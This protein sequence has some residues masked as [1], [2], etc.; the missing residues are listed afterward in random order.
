ME[1]ING[2]G[3]EAMK[4]IK[5]EPIKCPCCGLDMTAEIYGDDNVHIAV[6]CEH[7][8]YPSKETMNKKK[9]DEKWKIITEKGNGG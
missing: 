6:Y 3:G 5:M 7:C 9:E 8:G 1:R 4:P 2:R